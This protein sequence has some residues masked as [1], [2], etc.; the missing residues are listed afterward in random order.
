M[1]FHQNKKRREKVRKCE[2]ERKR[3]KGSVKER[4]R[5]IECVLERVCV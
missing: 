3:Q 5:E 2:R 4:G 1:V